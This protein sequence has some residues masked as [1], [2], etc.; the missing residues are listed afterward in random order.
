M[1][2][3]R[4][5]PIESFEL[6]HPMRVRSYA[7]RHGTGG[8]GR[9][10]G[11]DGVIREY[12]ALAPIEASVISERRR[13]A[14]AGAHHGADGVVG[15]NLVNGKECGGRVACTLLSGDLLRIETPGG[16]GWGAPPPA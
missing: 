5:T 10:R 16:G 14:P 15:R 11:G 7:L 3:T 1:S 2:N 6:D 9:F 13:H 12:E 4:N 8:A